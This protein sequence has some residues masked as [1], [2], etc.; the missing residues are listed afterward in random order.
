MPLTLNVGLSRKTSQNYHSQGASIN[1]TAE[2]DQALL[3]RLDELQDR[4]AALYR[5]AEHALERQQNPGTR[6]TPAPRSTGHNNGE[7]MTASQRRAIEAICKRLDANPIDEARHEFGL[8]LDRMTIREASK[9]IDH[10]KSSQPAG[11]GNGRH[12][13]ETRSCSNTNGGRR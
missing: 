10:L 7:G 2:L 4:V 12:H 3:N 1:L 5:E 11:N 6:D 13:S 9:F 8:D